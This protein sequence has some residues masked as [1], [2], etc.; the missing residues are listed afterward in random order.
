MKHKQIL[1]VDDARDLAAGLVEALEQLHQP[2][3]ASAVYSAEQ[4]LER[5]HQSPPDLMVTD[6]GLPGINGLELVRWVRAFY[7]HMPTIL[8]TAE[9]DAA[10]ERQARA[11]GAWGFMTKPFDLQRF[12]ET[13]GHVL[14]APRMEHAAVEQRPASL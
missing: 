5:L 8:I 12:V 6:L 13:V 7:P 1:I 14:H 4:A 10:I 9:A 3:R 2:Y 11:Y